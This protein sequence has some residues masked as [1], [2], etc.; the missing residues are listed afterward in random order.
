MA[1]RSKLAVV[2]RE[3]GVSVSTVSKVLRAYP[4][5]APATRA[6]VRDVLR[7]RGYSGDVSAAGHRPA[8]LVDVVLASPAPAGAVLNS[9]DVEARRTGLSVVVTTVVPD[10]PVPR[11]WLDQVSARGTRGVVGVLVDFTQAQLGYLAA[12]DVPLV[13]IAP[14]GRT[15][16]NVPTIAL[17]NDLGETARRVLATLVQAGY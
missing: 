2:A 16:Q 1:A 17:G 14:P 8:A 3:A 12:H 7:Q 9:F 10:R 5:V 15:P 6:R 11:H 13:L 4:D